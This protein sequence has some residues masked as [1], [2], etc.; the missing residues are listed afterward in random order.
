MW[1]IYVYMYAICIVLF[2]CCIRQLKKANKIKPHTLTANTHGNQQILLALS[3]DH[4]NDGCGW[5]NLEG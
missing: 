2:Y 5:L 1:Y 4:Y 3:C